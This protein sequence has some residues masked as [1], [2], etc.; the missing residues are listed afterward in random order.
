MALVSWD[1]Q[2]S[3]NVEEI[4]NQHKQLISMINELHKAM[5]VGKSKEA[6][7]QTLSALANYTVTHFAYEE[8]RFDQ[9]GYLSAA[10]HKFEHKKF[11]D[12]VSEFK[13]RFDEGQA[14][15]SNELI[16]FLKDWLISHIQGVDKKYTQCF[17]D[18]GLK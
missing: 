4:D 14:M 16:G 13:K 15:L 1:D 11:V 5:S 2:L 18:N 6:M 8:K 12:K 7:G 10:T 3:V 9:F 17:N